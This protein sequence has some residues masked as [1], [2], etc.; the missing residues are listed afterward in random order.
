ML[1]TALNHEIYRVPTRLA[2]NNQLNSEVN[3]VTSELND[4]CLQLPKNLSP[5][6][7]L[8]DKGD[9]IVEPANDT[10][11]RPDIEDAIAASGTNLVLKFVHVFTEDDC[12]DNEVDYVA[13][14]TKATSADIHWKP[15]S[16]SLQTCII[17]GGIVKDKVS[18]I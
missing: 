8:T 14:T 11:P 12:A 4:L 18:K 7:C 9:K 3:I 17:V 10:F 16:K 5:L 2:V 13:D 15:D 1:L 6:I